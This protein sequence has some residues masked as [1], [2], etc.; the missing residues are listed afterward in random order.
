MQTLSLRDPDWFTTFPRR[1]APLP[2]EWLAGLLLRCDETNHWESGETF[3]YLLRS[4]DHPDFGVESSLVVVP[5]SLLECLA[6]LLMIS[7]QQLLTTTYAT[8]LARLYPAHEPH[9]KL[10]L[11]PGYFPEKWLSRYRTG[12]RETSRKHKYHVCPACIAQTRLI[13]RT[14]ALPYLQ[15]C[16]LHHIALQDHCSCGTPL[17]FFSRGVPPFT[18]SGC[19]LDWAQ[20]P[21]VVVPPTRMVLDRNTWALYEFFLAQGTG[22]LRASA[23]RLALHQIPEGKSLQ[24]KLRRKKIPSGTALHPNQLALGYLIDILVSVGITPKDIAVGNTSLR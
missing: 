7:P 6:P 15:C 10:L 5:F 4:T 21:Q 3:R 1:V 22:E 24:L 20:W 9:P 19:G 17:L 23:L 2:G 16:P 14:E 12:H 11:G 13:K 8:E 18:C